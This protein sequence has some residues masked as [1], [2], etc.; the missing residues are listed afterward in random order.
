MV[1]AGRLQRAE[2]LSPLRRGLIFAALMTP[3]VFYAFCWNTENFLRP[4]MAE[5]LALSKE[6]VAAFYTLQALGALIGAVILS[7]LA[8]KYGRRRV[9]LTVI[10]G[11]GTAAISVLLVRDYATALLQRIVMGFFLGGVFGCAVSL[12]VGLFSPAIRGVLA[13]IVQLVYNGG[14]ALLSWFGRQYGPHNWRH[15]LVI[16]GGGALVAAVIVW[17]VV[18]NDRRF[19]PW[20]DPSSTRTASSKPPSIRELFARGWWRLTLRLAL[21]CG[22]NFFA[23]QSFNGWATTYLREIQGM[24]ADTVGRVMTMLHVGSMIGALSWGVVADR[25]GRRA[26][27]LGFALAAVFIIVYL[28]MP[29]SPVAFGVVGF[30]YGFCLVTSGIWGPYF[31]ELY[32][33]HLRT[34]AASIFG[35]GRVVSLFGALISGAIAERFGLATAM[36]VG[37]ANFAVAAVIWWSLPETLN[38][39]ARNASPAVHAGHSPNGQAQR[40]EGS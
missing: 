23:F 33:S 30:A 29:P 36:Y 26:N 3:Y 7:Q 40:H 9:F 16:G 19:I 5:S 15:V 25:F 21:L 24:S 12:Y 32:P 34:M 14:D 18:P 4:Y 17:L 27:A 8:D 11:F 28:R 39:G 20:T 38:R 35:W 13:G 10:I 2:D 6:Q 1:S 37:S 31:A 22:L